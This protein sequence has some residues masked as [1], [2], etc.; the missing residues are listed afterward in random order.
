[1]GVER[2]A[3]HDVVGVTAAQARGGVA[4]AAPSTAR[5]ARRPRMERTVFS[6]EDK[7]STL[8]KQEP[9]VAL[10]HGRDQVE[11]TIAGPHRTNIEGRY[12][13]NLLLVVALAVALHACG[14]SVNWRYPRT[15]S[16]AFTQPE[17]TSVGALFHRAAAQH[18][19]LSGFL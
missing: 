15:P 3:R 18:Q 19:G 10:G 11:S 6:G 17:T 7:V 5:P 4:T 13:G 1:M 12:S 9:A 16:T 2:L 14:A 8:L